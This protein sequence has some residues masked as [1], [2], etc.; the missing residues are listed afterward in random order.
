[1]PLPFQEPSSPSLTPTCWVCSGLRHSAAPAI[2]IFGMII[3]QSDTP[4]SFPP[5][6]L[7]SQ[8]RLTAYNDADHI[9]KYTSILAAG[10]TNS[11]PPPPCVLTSPTAH[12]SS[13]IIY[14]YLPMDCQPL[15][16]GPSRA[17]ICVCFVHSSP[18]RLLPWGALKV[19]VLNA[20]VEYSI[21]ERTLVSEDFW[22]STDFWFI[23][24]SIIKLDSQHFPNT[25]HV[26]EISYYFSWFPFLTNLGCLR[27]WL[28]A[29]L[30]RWSEPTSATCQSP[31]AQSRTRSQ[32]IPNHMSTFGQ[33]L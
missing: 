14:T 8:L 9:Q 27:V 18:Q 24:C 31:I 10:V 33:G 11:P 23:F 29:M 19:N 12:N 22:Y 17:G 15:P 1:M 3:P 13:H 21:W 2:S 28:I 20:W 16:H 30:C 26:C 6:L 7:T 5:P 25:L 4:R 32:Q